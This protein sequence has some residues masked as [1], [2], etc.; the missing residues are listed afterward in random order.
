MSRNV[1]DDRDQ[2]RFEITVDGALAGFAEYELRGDGKTVVFTHTE[3]FPE[4]E[5]QG[6]GGTLARGALDDVRAAGREVVPL[7]P[8]IRSWIQRHPDYQNLLPD[9]G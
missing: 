7:C 8:F 9:Q 5:G 1:T 3:V 4:F 2:S 6:V